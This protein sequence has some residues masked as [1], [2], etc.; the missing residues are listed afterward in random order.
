[1]NLPNIFKKLPF[2]DTL[3][4]R[5]RTLDNNVIP[6]DNWFV[7]NTKFDYVYPTSDI[8]NQ[9]TRLGAQ[10]PCAGPRFDMIDDIWNAPD[11]DTSYV[12]ICVATGP[13]NFDDFGKG[14]FAT[15]TAE[16]IITNVRIT[17]RAFYSGV[18]GYIKH[19]LEI[20]GTKYWSGN[21]THGILE[22]ANKSYDW[23]TNPATSGSWT[24][25]VLD[26]L[27]SIGFEL[28]RNGMKVT[29][30]YLRATFKDQSMVSFFYDDNKVRFHRFDATEDH[31]IGNLNLATEDWSGYTHIRLKIKKS[32]YAGPV[33]LKLALLFESS[34]ISVTV[35]D[36]CDFDSSTN[37]ITC[38]IPLTDFSPI[39]LT[40]IDGIG[41]IAD[42]D[43]GDYDFTIDD[44]EIITLDDEGNEVYKIQ[45]TETQGFHDIGT[46]SQI[47]FELGEV[48]DRSGTFY[49]PKDTEIDNNDYIVYNDEVYR[50]VGI[51]DSYDTHLVIETV[52]VEVWDESNLP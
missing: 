14:A 48:S 50:V 10:A 4:I 32:T 24:K 5:R 20:S 40:E 36:Y 31:T 12:E 11:D 44:L 17:S 28:N 27:D 25:A 3:I 41:F 15:L 39:D 23:A 51:N 7:E 16:D 46:G 43:G 6:E 49:L 29:Q 18:G 1:M 52:L 34:W 13:Q 8:S 33:G 47:P 2:Q 21:L 38:Q 45:D 22:Y 37:E 30:F 9:T 19:H 26:A 35:G 42:A